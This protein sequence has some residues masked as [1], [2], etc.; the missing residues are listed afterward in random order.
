MPICKKM[1]EKFG[2]LEENVYFCR[3]KVIEKRIRHD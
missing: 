1:A 2:S 3:R